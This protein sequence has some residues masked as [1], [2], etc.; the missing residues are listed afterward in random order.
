M[1][2]KTKSDRD[3]NTGRRT[4]ERSDNTQEYEAHDTKSSSTVGGSRGAEEGDKGIGDI[5]LKENS[6]RVT[7]GEILCN[8]FVSGG[9][10]E[11]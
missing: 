2:K 7:S 1:D 4:C 5:K 10:R 11:D 6:A 8:V 3:K 9:K